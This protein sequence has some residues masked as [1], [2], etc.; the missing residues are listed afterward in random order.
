MATTRDTVRMDP[1]SFVSL[2]W[3][4]K[5]VMLGA[6]KELQGEDLPTL[7]AQDL[8][9]TTPDWAQTFLDN[10]R[11]YI[12]NNENGKRP[13]FFGALA[14]QMK[15][16]WIASGIL[17]LF[18]IACMCGI[19]LVLQQ[20]ID[21]AG[22][23]AAVDAVDPAAWD[24]VPIPANMFSGFP[25]FTKS[26][27]AIAFLLL[28]LKVAS[29]IFGRLH[30]IIV[31]RVAFNIR[32]VLITAIIKK[33]LTISASKANEFSKGYVL[34]LVNVDSESV[35]I[36]A[37]QIH[38]LWGLPVQITVAI[39]LLASMLGSSIG[40]GIGALLASFA[41]LGVT[42]PVFIIASLPKLVAAN[43]KRV[44]LI[45]EAL[46]GIQLIKIRSL[47]EE[48]KSK[49]NEARL[50]QLHWLKRFL[51]GVVS[52]VVIGQ[53]GNLLTVSAS[54][55]LYAYRLDGVNVT[56]GIIFPAAALFGLLVMPL[57]QFPQVLNSVITAVVS[58]NRIY[59]FLVAPDREQVPVSVLENFAISLQGAA[60]HW[61]STV[62]VDSAPKKEPKRP[63]R[64]KKVA[65]D[66][67]LELKEPMKAEPPRN[68][69]VNLD[70]HIEKGTFV[71]VIGSVG[72]GKS[73]LLSAILGD[74]EK[75]A[76]KISTNGRIAYCTQQP[77]IRTGTIEENV[78]FGD[79]VNHDK[80]KLAVTCTC[81]ASDLANMPSGLQTVLGEKGSSV[82]GG[83]KTRISLA[84]A[85]YS[86]ADIFLLDDPLSS[87]DAKVSRT[88][89][90]DCF[91]TALKG[92]TIVLAT[93]NHDILKETDHIVFIQESGEIIQ[94]THEELM[95]RREFT[96]FVTTV[97]DSK[98]ASV[99]KVGPVRSAS[100]HAAGK[101]LDPTS[102][103]VAEES[104][105]GGVKA[106]TYASYVR[107]CGG[108][109]TI[110][111]LVTIIVLQQ[112]CGVIQNQWLTWWTQDYLLGQARDLSFWTTWYNVV[113]V[114]GIFFL[115]VLNLVVHA[116]IMRSTKVFHEGAISGV[117]N[118]PMWWFES[119]QI[120]RIM[121][122]FTK[123]MSAIDQRLLPQVFQFV[124]GIGGLFS[125]IAILAINSPYLLIGVVP[126][127]GLY[128]YVLK[129]YRNTM[130]QLKRLES[131]QRSPLYAHLSESLEGVTTISAYNKQQHF[132]HLTNNLLD[133]SNSPLFFKMGAEVWI[134]LRLEL[135][136]GLL[137][138]A[139]A[140]LSTNPNVIS[141]ENLG[142][143]L[144][145]TNNLTMLMNLIL[146]SA[147]NME[148][149]MVCVERLVEYAER[150]PVEGDA[151]LLMD[152]AAGTW[153][154]SGVIEFVNVSA[155]YK[156]KP[157]TPVLREISLRIE[158]GEKI[159]VVG[160]TGS[161]KS[162]LLSVLLRF[163]DMK[164]EVRI[165]GREINSVGLQTVRDTMEVIPQDIYLFSGTL[166]TTLDR[167]GTFS[168]DQLWAT[169][170]SVGLKKFVSNLEQKLDT[171]VENGGSNL[172]LGQRQ[173]LYFARILLLQRVHIVLMD[174]ATSSVDPETETT[175]RK[176][177]Q[178]QFGGTTIVSVLHRLQ[179]SVL[180]DFD[181]VL[182]MDAG[183]I[184]EFDAPKTLL[185]KRG[186]I[187]ASLYQ[188]HSSSA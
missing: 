161:G 14:A 176:V 146:Q 102:I 39:G 163:V 164:G 125:V 86:N 180:E 62:V 75:S 137:V 82:S 184:V 181:K 30:D 27:W 108:W 47:G 107:A 53:L 64:G 26:V 111:A 130:R 61:P 126:L 122:R 59:N 18:S 148:T 10:N 42:V 17:F 93:H 24:S 77:W 13:S 96:D 67:P 28:G 88:V 69:L 154:S 73:S 129:F 36:A 152:P 84:R 54:F 76:G 188:A 160:R 45:R 121:N 135:L 177:I 68:V 58:W 71:A 38:Q 149:E 4:T 99:A 6:K 166:R 103:I 31:K 158:S 79:E 143:S 40:A 133:F 120:G 33:S 127:T 37:E 92:K 22:F 136:S 21:L 85:V 112:A 134:L 16:L 169:L 109:A 101:E 100:V 41:I 182:V 153:P 89:F 57:I 91:K 50:E 173:L 172:S 51:Y 20:V 83:Q 3:M 106:E 65:E 97:D 9:A 105:T 142:V 74:L 141:A 81:L 94:G 29:T 32:S 151:R 78:V 25:L 123:D 179:A 113:V 147:A 48:F 138:F 72:S 5:I 95:M 19:P 90:N 155:F 167:E 49:I 183:S 7:K 98:S 139:L 128:L 110:W 162:T 116:A 131:T 55:T 34:N 2:S 23:K 140:C 145:F 11:A 43:D 156:S 60:F 178:E 52:F 104:E 175:L 144:L 132:G 150:L 35:A 15:R 165:D 63:K 70:L 46:D 124:S 170:E 1:W 186:S 185:A 174:E 171:P 56:A 117:L 12:P 168:D 44:K 157:E 66:P 115:V 114:I 159:C 187:F 119:Q 87:L 8:A 80:L 118:A